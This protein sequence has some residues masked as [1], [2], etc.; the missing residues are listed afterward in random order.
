M[1]YIYYNNKLAIRKKVHSLKSTERLTERNQEK[2]Y[3]QDT[4]KLSLPH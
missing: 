3:Y 4:K 2:N 1:G